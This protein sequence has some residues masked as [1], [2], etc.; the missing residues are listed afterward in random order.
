MPAAEFGSF[1]SGD[2]YIVLKTYSKSSKR[3]FDLHYWQGA[4]CSVDERGASAIR[5]VE[6]DDLLEGAPVQYRETQG[7]E[8]P[9]FLALFP[10]GLRYLDGGVETAFKH[11]GAAAY[12]PK[13]YQLKGRRTIRSKQV[14]LAASSLNDG[15]VFLLDAGLVLYQFNGRS[16]SRAEKYKALELATKIDGDER[17][18]KAS[19]VIVESGDATPDAA[20][21][22]KLIGGDQSQVQPAA[23]GGDDEAAAAID[24]P[25]LWRISDDGSAGS[26]QMSEVA[27]GKLTRAMLEEGNAMLL[28]AGGAITVWIG[29]EAS[30]G[31]RSKAMTYAAQYQAQ[32]NRPT[33]APIMRLPSGGETAEFKSFFVGFDRVAQAMGDGSASSSNGSGDEARKQRQL[34]LGALLAQRTAAVESMLDDASGSVRVWRIE[35]LQRVEVAPEHYGQFYSGDSF[36]VLYKYRT[37]SGRDSYVLYFWQGRES[38]TDEKGASALLTVNMAAELK[39]MAGTQVRVVQ[40]RFGS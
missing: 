25:S 33:Q 1:H 31:E 8:T 18:G 23:A 7:N 19:V 11:V 21:F 16:A 38:S 36:I 40:V 15:D 27:R 4:N 32:N 35:N 28:D 39:D 13:L 29:R 9:A 22:W 26:P 34:D 10:K 14:P 3:C 12:T 6:L 5:A 2:C 37:K 17:G 20:A 30:K 24:V